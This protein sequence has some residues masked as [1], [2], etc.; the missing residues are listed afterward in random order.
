M[1]VEYTFDQIIGTTL[2][3]YR[4][5]QFIGQSKMG[6]VFL[7]RTDAAATA[8]LLRFLVGPSNVTAS[9]RDDYLERF[10]YQASQ[11]AAL[12]HPYILPLLDY[13]IYRGIPYLVSPH[14]AMRSLHTR[15][16]KSGP[17]D[18]LT[19]GRYLDQVTAT[20]EYAH[21]H[22]VLHGSLSVDSIFI[23]L[24]GQ[25]AVAD[26]GVIGL[27]MLDKQDTRVDLLYVASEVYSPEQL[28]GKP[29]G[30]YTDVYA[31]GGGLFH[32]LTGSPV[33]VGNTPDEIAQQHLYAPVP[34][35]SQWRNDLPAGLYSIIA[36]ALAKDPA[37]RF[38]HPGALANAYHRNVI[39]SNRTRVPF[40]L[41]SSPAVQYQQP[42]DVVTSLPDVQV[43]EFERDG[44]GSHFVE[45]EPGPQRPEPQTPISHTRPPIQE[46]DALVWRDARRTALQRR[47][48]RKHVRRSVLIA[49]LIL[50]LVAAS[51]AIG[52]TLLSNKNSGVPGPTGQVIFFDGQN[53]P[54]GHSDTLSIG[55][56]GLDTPPSGSQ[57]TAWFIN[58]QSEEVQEL[59]TLIAQGQAFTLHYAGDSSNGRAGTN[60][61]GA[62]D[63]LE[64]T[65]EQGTVKLPTGKVVLAGTFPLKS[66]AHILHLLVGFPATPGKIGFLVGVLE[67]THLLNI[68]A[69]VLQSLTSSGDSTAIECAAQNMIDLIEGRQGAH[70]QPLAEPCADKHVSLT[71]DGF[72]LLGKGGYLASAEEH[73][74][75]AVTQP[76]A[77]SPMRLHAGLLAIALSNIKGWVTTIEQDALH[78]LTS[79]TDLVKVQEIATLADDAYHGVD[80]NGDG[81]IDPVAGEAGALTAYL[82]GQLMATLV[83]TPGT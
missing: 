9:S 57:Y 61:L 8:Y 47:F 4:L 72:G 17:L 66:Y 76:D 70:Y 37:Q 56:H 60:L 71:A 46:S 29:V 69:D 64:I 32:M 54:Q 59:G 2:G 42:L 27:L 55:V 13:G 63:K 48:Q 36:R 16:S 50:L 7:A 43:S 73:A 14:I 52:I 1:T 80:V 5:E 78:L 34:P 22:A 40:V 30:T 12:Q 83:L 75:F 49:A 65:L 39:P 24:D 21:Q 38:R 67:Q 74:T 81:Q 82:Q 68:Q 44:N 62:G 3:D 77:T 79:P 15:L 26:F 11:I 33:F 31:L 53:G 20:L 23:R 18:V 51:S 28:L 10:Q 58:D 25:L 45:R 19:V 35:L 6:P 41:P